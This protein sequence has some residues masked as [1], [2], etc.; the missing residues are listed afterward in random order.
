MSLS[1]PGHALDYWALRSAARF[2][3]YTLVKM[4]P[5]TTITS[6]MTIKMT[7]R[8]EATI[9]FPPRS[10]VRQQA[11]A[12]D[13]PDPGQQD[14]RRDPLGAHRG[15]LAGLDPPKPLGHR[16][17]YNRDAADGDEDDLRHEGD[18]VQIARRIGLQDQHAA[19][20]I[21]HHAEDPQWKYSVHG[22][23]RHRFPE[24]QDPQRHRERRAE[25]QRIAEEMH[26]LPRHEPD[27]LVDLF[28]DEDAQAG[29]GIGR[30]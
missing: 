29:I 27:H 25:D 12:Q 8:F 7:L 9:G 26:R 17:I 22:F 1:E 21:R 14:Q 24:T 10:H 20:H 6:E 23:E 11:A 3:Q 16:V 28:L 18:L 4:M 2:R 19:E 13:D 15:F 5:R 30:L